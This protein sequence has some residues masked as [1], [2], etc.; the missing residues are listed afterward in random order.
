MQR[1]GFVLDRSTDGKSINNTYQ[2]MEGRN[3]RTVIKRTIFWIFYLLRKNPD[4][5][6]I[7]NITQ[8]IMFGIVGMS[9]T[10]ISYFINIAVLGMLRAYH[11]SWDYI[12]GNIIAFILSVLWAFYWNNKYVF[13]QKNEEPRIV[14]K[15]LLKT[16]LSY[17][18]TGIVLTNILSYIWIVLL[19]ISKY[20]A[21]LL[22]Y[23]ICIPINFI[24]NKK[25]AFNA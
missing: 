2:V 23:V 3:L 6:A 17:G 11:F 5:K 14:W 24:L 18:F 13:A 10:F 22:C 8:I 4:Q 16:Y 20:V 12:A 21:P 7:D 15:T 9:N 19:G 1:N 25:W